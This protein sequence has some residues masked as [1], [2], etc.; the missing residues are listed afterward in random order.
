MF[1]QT[2]FLGGATLFPGIEERLKNE[3]MICSTVNKKN[4]IK[5]HSTKE[6][7]FSVWKGASILSSLSTFQDMLITN[8]DY[9]E[10]GKSIVHI[11]C[12]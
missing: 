12:F 2:I 1:L 9:F 3:L 11:K 7:K 10:V 8:E 6:R 5:I 4:L